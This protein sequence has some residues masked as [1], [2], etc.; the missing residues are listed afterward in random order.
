MVHNS[1]WH[2]TT[3]GQMCLID[4]VVVS[5]NLWAYVLDTQVKRGAELA[6]NRHSVLVGTVASGR[7]MLCCNHKP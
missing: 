7:A 2:Q 6:V 5:L 4:F 3:L 1:A